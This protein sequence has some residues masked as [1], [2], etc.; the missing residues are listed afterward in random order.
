[1]YGLN[2]SVVISSTE[3]AKRF[4]KQVASRREIVEC[5]VARREL[6]EQIDV[7]GL[8]LCIPHKRTEQRQSL[9][10]KRA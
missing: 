4:F 5:L 1:M 3:R 7:A 9:D 2:D 6:D 8:D 10:A